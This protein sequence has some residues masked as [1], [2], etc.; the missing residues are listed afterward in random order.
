MRVIKFWVK[1]T[2]GNGARDLVVVVRLLA[3]V[4]VQPVGLLEQEHD[5]G[6]LRDVELAPVRLE[7]LEVVYPLCVVYLF[8]VLYHATNFLLHLLVRYLKPIIISCRYTK[9]IWHLTKTIYS[10]SL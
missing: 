8:L 9:T 5:V 7:L 6:R 1:L 2:R 10:S 3:S 4:L